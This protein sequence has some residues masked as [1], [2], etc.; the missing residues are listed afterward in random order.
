LYGDHHY[1][2]DDEGPRL[3]VCEFLAGW[4]GA[5]VMMTIFCDI[6]QFSAIFANFQRKN[7]GVFLKKYN[8]MIK[9]L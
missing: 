4:L 5:N 8:V 3:K 1:G 6:C 7:S 9:F 2:D